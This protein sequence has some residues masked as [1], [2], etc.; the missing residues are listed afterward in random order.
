MPLG[1]T[2]FIGDAQKRPKKKIAITT[3]ATRSGTARSRP[4]NWVPAKMNAAPVPSPKR[5]LD[6]TQWIG[7]ILYSRG[8]DHVWD[9][10]E[11]DVNGTNKNSKK[12]L[13]LIVHCFLGRRS[14]HFTEQIVFS[15]KFLRGVCSLHKW[16]SPSFMLSCKPCLDV[17]M[18]LYVTCFGGQWSAAQSVTCPP[19]QQ[20]VG[21]LHYVYR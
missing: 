15:L 20:C 3:L 6:Q 17:M 2:S 21:F 10:G 9:D 5:R 19:A 14:R 12:I 7:R 8:L 11:D 13:L 16:T 4:R 18:A 1:N